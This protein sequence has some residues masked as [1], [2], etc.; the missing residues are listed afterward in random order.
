M[1]GCNAIDSPVTVVT[2]IYI[3]LHKYVNNLLKNTAHTKIAKLNYAFQYLD[4]IDMQNT[5]PLR[6]IGQ[7]DGFCIAI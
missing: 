5:C 3:A 6:P 4:G 1:Y 7:E 2:L